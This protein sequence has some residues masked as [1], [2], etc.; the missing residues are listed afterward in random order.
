M[1]NVKQKRRSPTR[2]PI[3][4]TERTFLSSTNIQRN[5]LNSPSSIKKKILFPLETFYRTG[6]EKRVSLKTQRL[7]R[8]IY[9]LDNHNRRDK[10]SN[11]KILDNLI[12]F[13]R[14]F[15]KIKKPLH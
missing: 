13:R 12:E 7:N 11:T 8:Y 10:K 4:I 5:L 14:E 1:L 3:D 9:L 2:N 15:R 6:I